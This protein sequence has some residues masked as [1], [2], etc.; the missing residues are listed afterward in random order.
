MIEIPSGEYMGRY[1]DEDLVYRGDLEYE[2]G[3]DTIMTISYSYEL[4]K[5]PVTN[6]QFCAF[7]ITLADEG[8]IEVPTQQGN[9][10]Y[11]FSP[12]NNPYPIWNK[13]YYASYIMYVK[14]YPELDRRIYSNGTTFLV[15]EGFANHPIVLVNTEGMELFSSY[16]G[17]RLPTFHEFIKASRGMN[18]WSHFFGDECNEDIIHPTLTPQYYK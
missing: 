1:Y 6:A 3:I 10:Y 16:Y 17:M 12:E 15:E 18:A 11:D 13:G 9:L 5:Y 14:M 4:M 7:L 8:L 2:D